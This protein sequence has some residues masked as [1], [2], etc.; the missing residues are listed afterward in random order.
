MRVKILEALA[1]GLPLVA[2]PL[3]A[4]GIA[5]DGAALLAQTP[6]Q[7]ADALLTLLADAA[8]RARLGAAGR[9]LVAANYSWDVVGARLAALYD[10]LG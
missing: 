3:A 7:F 1:H 5:L 10:A 6:Q 8:L 2:T 9:A 4:E